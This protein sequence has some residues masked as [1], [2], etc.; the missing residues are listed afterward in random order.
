[1]ISLHMQ[2][3]CLCEN[4]P[5]LR[6]DTNNVEI[7][8]TIAPRPLLMVSATGDWTSNTLEREYP[9]VRALY[10]LQGAAD[11]VHAVRFEAPH[12]YNQASREAVYAWMARWLQNEPA[13][14]RREERPFT[15]DPL[16]DL[17]VFH[18]RPFPQNAVDAARLTTNWIDAAR[19]PVGV[20]AARSARARAEARARVRASAARGASRDRGEGRDPRRRRQVTVIVAGIDADLE[21]EMRSARFILKPVDFTPF[22]AAEAAKIPH[23]DTYNRTAASQRVADIVEALRASPDAVLVGAGDAAL[24]GLLALAIETERRA[25][26]RCRRFRYD[27]RCRDGRAAVY[28][29]PAPG[30]R[31]LYRGGACRRSR[32][33]PQRRSA[34]QSRQLAAERDKLTPKE[35]VALLK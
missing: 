5:G 16:P 18:H 27:K 28:A 19:A 2:G 8:A 26:S 21:K 30:R 14:A 17:L 29:R 33:N 12:N 9:A 6:I 23:F 34:F 10:A 3:G 22:N 1:M 25:H 11:R 32:V 4:Q 7:A 35:I 13:G 31:S 20:D 24:A 15:P